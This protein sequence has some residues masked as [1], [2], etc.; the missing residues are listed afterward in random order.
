[1]TGRSF[2]RP[3]SRSAVE[4]AEAVELG[5]HDVEQHEVVVLRGDRRE[6]LHAVRRLIDL[7]EVEALEPADQEVAVVRDIV[8]DEN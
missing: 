6:R 8:D 2:T 7:R 3:C 5:H 4:H 1:M